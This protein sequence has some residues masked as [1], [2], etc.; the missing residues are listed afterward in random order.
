VFTDLIFKLVAVRW[1]PTN[2]CSGWSRGM[3]YF[4]LKTYQ[5][6]FE[7]QLNPIFSSIGSSMHVWVCFG[8]WLVS[9]RGNGQDLINIY[10]RTVA[11]FN[12]SAQH[13][14]WHALGHCVPV[15][16]LFFF[17]ALIYVLTFCVSLP[18]VIKLKSVSSVCIRLH[19]QGNIVYLCTVVYL[20]ATT[21]FTLFAGRAERLCNWHAHM[22]LMLV[23]GFHL[24]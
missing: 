24:P 15:L 5:V 21:S 12:Q 6:Y 2:E 19:C 3:V 1:A 14:Q 13:S 23:R 22:V 10:L 9:L 20:K 8:C 17:P 7:L 16:Y 11:V 18:F 4:M